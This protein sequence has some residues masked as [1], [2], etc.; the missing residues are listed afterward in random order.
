M[1]IEYLCEFTVIARLGSFSRAAEELCISQSALSK[2]ILALE[3]ELDVQL[4]HRNSRNVS[5]S[6][7]GTQILPLAIQV[8]ELKNKILVAAAK[9]SSRQKSILTVASIPVMAQYNITGLLAKFQQTFPQVTLEV[10]ECEQQ[11]LSGLL[12]SGKSELAFSRKELEPVAFDYLEICRDHLVAV[13]SRQHPLASRAQIQLSDLK[14]EPL[15]FLDQQTG[16]HQLYGT[17]CLE[18]DF[19]PHVTYTGHRPENIVEMAAQNMGVALLMRRHTDYI[20]NPEVVCLDIAPMV[21]STVCLVRKK[22][23]KLSALAQRFWNFVANEQT[24]KLK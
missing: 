12:E 2:H 19:V 3:R 10:L 21:E 7:A 8:Y 20:A 17:L 5:L 13:V 18:A 1:D 11:E 16:F 22:G 24:S 4:F 9:Q 23:H 15:L 14:E 6:P